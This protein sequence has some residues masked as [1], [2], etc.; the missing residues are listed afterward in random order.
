MKQTVEL[1]RMSNDQLKNRLTDLGNSLM[2]AVGR[3]KA[4]KPED[5]SMYIRKLRKEKARILTLLR[6][7]E[8]KIN[9]KKE[10]KQ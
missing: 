5:D 9:M 10:K 8:L 4:G 7:R 3:N 1:R 6:E 2:R